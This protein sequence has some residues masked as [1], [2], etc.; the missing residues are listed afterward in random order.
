MSIRPKYDE[1]G[2]QIL[3]VNPAPMPEIERPAS[4]AA[5]LGAAVLMMFD[6]VR[7]P[8]PAIKVLSRPCL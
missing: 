1:L 8:V 4:R 2:Q 7:I 6:T 5:L 3:T